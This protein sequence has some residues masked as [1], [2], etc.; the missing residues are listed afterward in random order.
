MS[1]SC[2]FDCAG[3]ETDCPS[4]KAP[5]ENDR[6]EGGG[7]AG[8]GEPPVLPLMSCQRLSI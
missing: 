7:Q 4:R 5:Q 6:G 1:E 3:C 8:C 2:D